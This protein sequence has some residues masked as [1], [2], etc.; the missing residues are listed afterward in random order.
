MNISR[1]KGVAHWHGRLKPHAYKLPFA[2]AASA[3]APPPPPPGGQAV[4]RG[5]IKARG[6]QKA[7]GGKGGGV[8]LKEWRVK[9]REPAFVRI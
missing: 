8:K 3:C 2:F 6:G 7:R 9:K 1:N 4:D 5:Q